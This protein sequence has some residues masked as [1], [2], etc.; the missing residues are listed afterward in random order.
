MPNLTD[1]SLELARRI[2]KFAVVATGAMPATEV[3][4]AVMAAALNIALGL[5]TREEVCEWLN[6]LA[7]EI[8]DS[9]PAAQGGGLL[10]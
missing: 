6:R 10:Q 8:E 2:S 9:E 1:N 7:A 5:L 3:A 4:D